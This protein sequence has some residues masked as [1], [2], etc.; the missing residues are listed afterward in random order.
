MDTLNDFYE[1]INNTYAYF[2]KS[3][4]RTETVDLILQSCVYQLNSMEVKE[5]F[6][7]YLEKVEK[8]H[9]ALN[10]ALKDVKEITY[11][12]MIEVLKDLAYDYIIDE[13]EKDYI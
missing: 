12:I 4:D 10:I 13:I 3:Y 7:A 9:D 2:I 11:G 8:N 1:M 6:D 5:I